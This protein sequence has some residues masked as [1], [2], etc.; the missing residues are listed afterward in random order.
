MPEEYTLRMVRAEAQKRAFDIRYDDA[1]I[2]LDT[3]G[4]WNLK[5]WSVQLDGM[6][7][8]STERLD[9]CFYYGRKQLT[10]VMETEGGKPLR[11]EAVL[12]KVAIGPRSRAWL[13]GAGTL[14]GF[15]A[16]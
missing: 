8:D 10:L 1:R 5:S 11:G 15:Q 7:A 2:L 16:L 9:D 12:T 13:E 4:P 14:E 6:D 3:P